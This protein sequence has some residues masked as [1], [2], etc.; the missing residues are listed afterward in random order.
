MTRDTDPE[1]NPSD[2]DTDGQRQ[3]ESRP[4]R[5][6]ADIQFYPGSIPRSTGRWWPLWHAGRG[7]V[8]PLVRGQT[9]D[10]A[11]SG[12]CSLQPDIDRS[13]PELRLH[14]RYSSSSI[15][16]SVFVA[17]SSYGGID[18]H[19]T[20]VRDLRTNNKSISGWTGDS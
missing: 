6:E 8:V 4:I 7:R 18:S 17:A 19:T 3:S 12:G 14:A 9:I 15:C 10:M 11:D 20:R 13:Y 16:S 1:T 5:A 2:R